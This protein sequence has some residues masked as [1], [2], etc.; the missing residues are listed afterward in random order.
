MFETLVLTEADVSLLAGVRRHS[1]KAWGSN[2][3]VISYRA[4][5]LELQNNRCAYCQGI[6]DLDEVGHRELD[7]I[8]PK[9]ATENCT[10]AKGRSNEFVDRQH[11]FG[12]HQ[13]TYEPLN[14]V[15][16]CK[17]C[18]SYKKSFDPL[19]DR[20]IEFAENEYPEHE[21]IL[22]FYPYVHHYSHHIERSD[23]WTYT[24]LSAQGEAVIKVCKL[25]QAEVLA[26]R[27]ATRALMRARHSG[28]LRVASMNMA[29]EVMD[30]IFSFNHATDALI[31]ALDVSSEAATEI[32]NLC[33]RYL[34]G[35]E[36]QAIEKLEE[37]LA[38]VVS[39]DSFDIE[40]AARS[41]ST[42]S[43]H[44]QGRQG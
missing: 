5:L 28:N 17:V 33:L 15:V 42:H 29:T 2:A 35:G 38:V 34:Q 36:I 19:L 11:T 8:F 18:N 32:L 39:N 21:S 41:I 22:W 27:F 3:D 43:A 23:N 26:S 30:Q 44:M 31:A 12:Y 10:E 13:F 14:L 7:H 16:A 20:S 40:G 6:I 4:R 25:D 37:L 24:Q 9:S 1:G